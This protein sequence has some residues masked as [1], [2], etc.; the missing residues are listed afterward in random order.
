MCAAILT[1]FLLFCS[2]TIPAQLPSPSAQTVPRNAS[3]LLERAIAMSRANRGPI[4]ITLMQE[5]IRLYPDY[6]AAHLALGNELAKAGRV[7]D[8]LVE[9]EN[10]RKINPGNDEVY[11]SVGLMM[12]RLKRYDLAA[13]V[14]A[15]A[16]VLNPNEPLHHLMRGSALVRAAAGVK[17]TSTGTANIRFRFSKRDCD[18]GAGND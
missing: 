11:S 16:S 5:A 12:M 1:L 9:F 2:A 18:A 10:A 3:A 13:L 4:A 6:F 14:F 17:T 15:D 8:A 7:N